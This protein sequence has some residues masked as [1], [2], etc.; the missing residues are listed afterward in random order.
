MLHYELNIMPPTDT[1]EVNDTGTTVTVPMDSLVAAAKY[2]KP[3]YA[4]DGLTD[5]EVLE[6]WRR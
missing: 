1:A 6:K 4:T 5:A 3:S 2:L